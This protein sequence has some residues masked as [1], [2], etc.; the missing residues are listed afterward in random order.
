M[1]LKHC[2]ICKIRVT[3]ENWVIWL[4]KFYC[5][6]CFEFEFEDPF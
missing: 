3:K 2:T 1:K 5:E 4:S 6:S